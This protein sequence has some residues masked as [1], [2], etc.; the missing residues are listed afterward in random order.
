[1]NSAK[2]SK[3]KHSTKSAKDILL[4]HDFLTQRQKSQKYINHEFQ[5]FGYYLATELNDMSHRAIYM[6]LA[7]K[8]PKH[9][10]EKALS[11][12]RDYD[13]V[14][15]KG[16]LFMWKLKEIRESIQLK[17]D[18]ENFD[19]EFIQKRMGKLY[20]KLH[21]G[22]IKKYMRDDYSGVEDLI[23]RLTIKAGSRKKPKA[24][25]FDSKAG[26]ISDLLSS[27]GLKVDDIQISSSI[28]DHIKTR[29][30]IVNTKKSF[31]LPNKF[32]KNHY[33]LIYFSEFWNFIPIDKEMETIDDL[34]NL[35]AK[36]GYL[37]ISVKT[38]EKNIQSWSE[39]DIGE[40]KEYRFVKYNTKDRID[41]LLNTI[42]DSAS[43]Q[44]VS[45]KEDD[46]SVITI[47]LLISKE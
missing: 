1:M 32:K 33:S 26:K 5:D 46:N 25:V 19:I 18:N 39:F 11:F 21:V 30:P 47:N 34:I 23:K 41:E 15:N 2:M 13:N 14:P 20:D 10:L 6:S 3:K 17:Q 22:L 12:A 42:K 44:I 31:Y 37:Y 27:I 43:I 8:T 9:I 36:G 16:K 7:K 4:G 35:L 45:E 38:Y 24:I 40:D 29:Y 28:R